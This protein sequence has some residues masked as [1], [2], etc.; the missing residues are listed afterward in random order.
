MLKSF[1]ISERDKK[2]KGNT[3]SEKTF[4]F[5]EDW[6]IFFMQKAQLMSTRSKDPSTKVG[7]LIVSPD[8]VILSAGY[9]GFP[10]GI[11]DTPERLNDRD[12]KYP[13]V[14]HSE[15]NAII[16]AVRNGTIIR[17][18]IVFVTQPPCPECTKM[19]VN[20]EI[21]ELL[22]MDLDENKKDLP[23][24]REKLHISF[25]MLDEAGIPHKI[26]PNEFLFTQQELANIRARQLKGLEL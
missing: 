18:A 22:H 4:T 1:V 11:K 19:L 20:T 8:R 15:T 6:N 10:R 2:E 21:R 9:N 5:K 23:G 13:R 14:V 16:N 17:D 3:M 26:I 7:C 25:D 24:W 12:L